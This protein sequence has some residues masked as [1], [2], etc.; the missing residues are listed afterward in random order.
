MQFGR[1]VPLLSLE[2]LRAF[3][4]ANPDA[5]GTS[6]WPG[7]AFKHGKDV[8]IAQKESKVQQIVFPA[9]HAKTHFHKC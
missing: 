1:I 2:N 3:K 6:L 7:Q 4:K 9:W 8:F 5:V